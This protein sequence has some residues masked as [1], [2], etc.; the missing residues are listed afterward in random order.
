M[1][2]PNLKTAMQV[3]ALKSLLWLALLATSLAWGRDFV[4]AMY[5]SSS[6]CG[7][8]ARGAECLGWVVWDR[9]SLYDPNMDDFDRRFTFAHEAF[10]AVQFNYPEF[11]EDWCVPD[12][13]SKG[14]GG[15]LMEGMADAVAMDWAGSRNSS[16]KPDPETQWRFDGLR[17]YRRS[18]HRPDNSLYFYATS[19]FWRYLHEVC[20]DYSLWHAVLEN[21]PGEAGRCPLV[22]GDH[23]KKELVAKRSTHPVLIV[24]RDAEPVES[25]DIR[26]Y[27]GAFKSALDFYRDNGFEE[28][29][30]QLE[31]TTLSP[32]KAYVIRDA[33]IRDD[34]GTAR[35]TA[36]EEPTASSQEIASADKTILKRVDRNLS[37]FLT[38]MCSGVKNVKAESRSRYCR[39]YEEEKVGGLTVAYLAFINAFS[40]GWH[41]GKRPYHPDGP[42]KTPVDRLFESYPK[43]NMPVE[44]GCLT[45]KEGAVELDIPE[46]ASVC[47]ELESPEYSV[48]HEYHV[49]VSGPLYALGQLHLGWHGCYRAPWGTLADDSSIE[50]GQEGDQAT[51]HK[52][53]VLKPGLVRPGCDSRRDD[54]TL[55]LSNMARK[56]Y[57]TR[58]T[59]SLQFR[60]EKTVDADLESGP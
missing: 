52:F 49:I 17:S 16:V 55:V 8:E 57:E 6:V 9:A 42:Y 39:S 45:L 44:R 48:R 14:P 13:K 38:L 35:E 59:E 27:V 40:E 32:E 23:E 12:T 4:P 34:A 31:D 5:Q 3:T 2:K 36:E 51:G 26:N 25:A 58:A 50:A 47:V 11:R 21:H 7:S 53:W 15:W 33:N 22:P 37:Y 30:L 10:H 54:Y 1:S 18:L 28:P 43:K 29:C 20:G 56:A 24:D 46:L 41:N 19:S 60:I